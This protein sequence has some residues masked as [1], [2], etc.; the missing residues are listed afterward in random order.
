MAGDSFQYFY[1]ETK[2]LENGNLFQKNWS[3]VYWLKTQHFHT[4]LPC[5]KPMLG[6][7]KWEVQNVYIIKNRVLRLTTLFFKKFCSSVRTSSKELIKSTTNP[8]VHIHKSRKRWIFIWRCFSPVSI[9]NSHY[10]NI[11]NGT[12]DKHPTKLETLARK[13][14]EKNCSN[15]HWQIQK[16]S[17]QYKYEKWISVKCRNKF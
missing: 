7:I 14:S 13:V 6:Q 9:L 3:S 17:E 10:I 5:Q 4:K 1:L 8:N 2:F 11:I 12:T 16:S 15:Y